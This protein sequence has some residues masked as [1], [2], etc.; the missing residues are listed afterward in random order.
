MMQN[1]KISLPTFKPGDLVCLTQLGIKQIVASHE[2][3]LFPV[4]PS[5]HDDW[6]D[7]RVTLGYVDENFGAQKFYIEL[8][9][10]MPL[11]LLKRGKL[12]EHGDKWWL[13][14]QFLAKDKAIN[15]L[16]K[17]EVQHNEGDILILL[18]AA[19]NEI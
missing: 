10:D 1:C 18:Q 2:Y 19:E 4:F 7:Y 16:F 5:D 15:V 17:S 11:L 12:L 6:N 9:K 13:M 8:R 3:E 14:Y